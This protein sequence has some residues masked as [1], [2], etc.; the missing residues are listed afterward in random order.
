MTEIA[1]ALDTQSLEDARALAEKVAPHVHVLKIGLELFLAEGARATAIARDLARPLFLDLKL[2]D[3]PE[4]V[5]RAVSSAAKH[6]AH[7]VTVHASGGRAMLERA[8]K[9]GARE[10]VNVTA[11]TVLTSLA[12]DDLAEAG[13]P[14]SA[15]DHAL[16]LARLAFACG[17][18]YFVCSPH[19]VARMRA[20][21]GPSATLVTPGIRPESSDAGD[22][23]RVATPQAAA[24]AGA[25]MLV[26]G[27]PI[28]DA[29]DPAEAARSIAQSLR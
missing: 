22:Q 12:D 25:N 17:V 15:S 20:E 8:Q 19:E 23:K 2:H 28:R 11:V 29:P 24:H 6:G 7:M 1:V 14:E 27:R 5:E 9:R 3:I 26:I 10:G 4:T 21:L 16:R 18:R 13:I